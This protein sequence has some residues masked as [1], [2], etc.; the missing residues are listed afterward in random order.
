MKKVLFASALVGLLGASV[1]FA[2][3]GDKDCGG[4]GHHGGHGGKGGPGMRVEM[5]KDK[6]TLNDQQVTEVEKIMQEQR[7]KMDELRKQMQEQMKANRDE[8]EKRIAALLTPEQ[9]TTFQKMQEER[10]KRM[11]ERRAEMQKRLDDDK[12]W[13]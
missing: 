1:A 5:L 6:L 2:G 3:P 9:T 12:G 7:T 8:S 10:Q 11:E 13:F 4:F